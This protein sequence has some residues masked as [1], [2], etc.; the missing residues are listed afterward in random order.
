MG[1]FFK[2]NRFTLATFGLF[3]FIFWHLAKE[4]LQVRPDGWYVGQI[5]LY[6][7]LVLHLSFINKILETNKILVGSPIFAGPKP[8]YPIAADFITAQ[9]AKITGVD[10]AL[11]I[12]TFLMGLIVI[13]SSRVFIRIFIRND[14]VVFLS[15]LL[16]FLNGGFGFYYFFQ[17]LITN[18]NSL[19]NFFLAMPHQYTDIKDKSYWWINSYL[20]YFLPQRGFLF[21]FPI[22]LIVLSLLYVGFKRKKIYFFILAGL[23]SGVMPLVQAH[24]LFV[25]FLVSAPLALITIL[26]S[27]KKEET[28]IFWSIFA[29][30]TAVIALPSFLSISSSGAIL[31]SIR[32]E[33]G[34]T[35]KENIILF[36][37]KNLGLFAPILVVSLGWLY[38]KNRYLFS[39]YLPFLGIFLISNILVFQP[40]EF[41][42][43]KL[44]IYWFF[45]SAI[46]VAYFL[47]DQF[48]RENII[49]KILGI[50]IIF[51]MI[52]SGSL[53]IFRTFTPVTSYQIFTS[54][55]LEIATA[56][57]N[58]TPK[59]AVFVTASNHNNPIPALSGRATLL[60]FHGWVW[61]HG[62]DYQNREEDIKT[63]YLGGKT[64]EDLI[65]KY[66]VNYVT[67][68]PQEKSMF[69]VNVSYFE[70]YPKIT[71]GND[72][73]IY[74]VSNLF[75][76]SENHGDRP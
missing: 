68:S 75:Q 38:K 25:I 55:D 31:K 32:F 28:F 49:K 56:V 30:I 18:Q 70:T 76:E 22:T 44:L 6:G 11:F 39:L 60:G 74:D 63:I 61:S 7:D 27:Q 41:D 48:F 3:G 53:D 10:F 59:D 23:L 72:W 34:W 54:H 37:I 47:D 43:S 2:V 64:A 69:S 71:L 57:K 73:Q 14:R 17:D 35:S 52:L 66:K 8:N 65:A 62:L 42:N 40:W 58:L 29:L 9:V 26:K 50:L 46:I 15:L 12:I 45:T 5:N 24:S 67:I 36:W 51:I 33:P 19:F 21:A 16:F 20:A 13:Y 1:K 4:M